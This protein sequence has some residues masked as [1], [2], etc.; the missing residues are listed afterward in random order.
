MIKLT[1]DNGHKNNIKVSVCGEMGADIASAL[2]LLGFGVDELSVSPIKILELKKVIRSV[3]Y[4]DLQKLADQVL[5]NSSA[6][7]NKK[8][9]K[10][11]LDKHL[12]I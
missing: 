11:W 10:N 8:I 3:N 5:N 1:I 2:V 12:V 4:C 9:I 6:I 7:E